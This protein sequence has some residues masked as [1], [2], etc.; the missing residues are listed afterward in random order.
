VPDHLHAALRRVREGQAGKAR[1]RPA[2]L[3]RSFQIGNAGNINSRR[4]QPGEVRFLIQHRQSQ[5]VN[6]RIARQK[7]VQIIVE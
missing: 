6:A 5:N 4:A 2:R 7:G 3:Y 1:N